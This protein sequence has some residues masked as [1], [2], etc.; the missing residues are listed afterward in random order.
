[1]NTLRNTTTRFGWISIALHWTLAPL[2]IGMFVLG[3]YM[4]DLDYYDRWYHDS[5]QWHKALG[6]I[7][8][9]AMVF[10]FLWNRLQPKPQ[11]LQIKHTLQNRLANLGH[12]ALY[13]LIFGLGVS[14]YLISTAKGQGIDIFGLFE[15]PAFLPDNAERSE[16]AGEIHEIFANSFLILVIVHALAAFMHH[17]YYKDN[18]LKRILGR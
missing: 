4:V 18:T 9:A 1:M 12:W 14:G 2:L 17:F 15:L 6:V 16:F 7:I 8:V 10:R 3:K 5:L 13:L 11:P